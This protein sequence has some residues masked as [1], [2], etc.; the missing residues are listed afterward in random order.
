MPDVRTPSRSRRSL[1]IGIQVIFG[2]VLLA[3]VVQGLW[4]STESQNGSASLPHEI[5]GVEALRVLSGPEAMQAIRELHGK[6]VGL[7]SGY[8]GYYR[9]DA[10]IWVGVV[11][12]E[13]AAQRL[14]EAMTRGIRAGNPMFTN[15]QSTLI[16][17]QT[18]F[19]VLSGSQK[20]YYYQ[21]GASVIWVTPPATKEQEFL[22]AALKLI[23]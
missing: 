6:D 8:V 13:P 17:G 12:N 7:A 20:H 5:A 11:E 4:L 18:V 16:N 19:T 21:K 23:K 2:V 22:E 3:A 9:N 1:M 15:L 14:V 10:M